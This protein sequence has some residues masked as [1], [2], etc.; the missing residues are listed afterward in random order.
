MLMDVCWPVGHHQ[1]ALWAQVYLRPAA[2]WFPR[3]YVL[4]TTASTGGPA[5]SSPTSSEPLQPPAH[6]ASTCVFSR[7]SSNPPATA[8]A[9]P[10]TPAWCPSVAS[11]PTPLQPRQ[12]HH[13]RL[14]GV[15]PWLRPLPPCNRVSPT[16]N[17]CVVSFRGFGPYPP[18]T[19]SAPPPTPAWCPSTGPSACSAPSPRCSMSGRPGSSSGR[20]RRRLPAWAR[21]HRATDRVR[22]HR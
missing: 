10:P 1:S 6:T 18:A 9:P 7:L 15:L 4:L 19:A 12:P 8:S 2:P 13:Q 17:A 5:A 20:S 11:A 14:R 22:Q 3:P 21:A 16:T